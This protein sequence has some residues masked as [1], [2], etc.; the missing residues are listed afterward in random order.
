MQ[1]APAAP[2]PTGLGALFQL[3][4]Q[5]GI[6][7]DITGLEGTQRNAAAALQEAFQTATTFGTKAADLALQGRMTKDIDKAMRTIQTAQSQGLITDE[8]ARN[9]SEAA[10]R[11]MVGA[12]PDSPKATTTDEVK[13]LTDTAGK[14]NA[15]LSVT[16]QRRAGGRRRQPGDAR[17]LYGRGATQG[18]KKLPTRSGTQAPQAWE[19]LAPIAARDPAGCPSGLKNLGTILFVHDAETQID[20]RD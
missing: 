9:L 4:G 18:A 16:A 3:L 20:L 17:L 12:G 13:D 2:D 6:F 14:N 5:S 19:G 1:S 8:Q 15:S 7:K 11:G 10:I